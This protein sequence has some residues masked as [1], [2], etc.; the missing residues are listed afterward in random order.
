MHSTAVRTEMA[1]VLGHASPEAID[2]ELAFKDFGFDSLGAIE[3]RN[4]LNAASGLRLPATLI[5]DYPTPILV[6]EHLLAELFPDARP[7]APEEPAEE[8]VR[9]AAAEEAIDAMDVE[10][11]IRMSLEGSGEDVGDAVEDGGGSAAESPEDPGN[12][13]E[14][15]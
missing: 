3:L 12:P 1:A 10:G 8:A 14:E 6:A 7:Q 5:F 2:P 11:L 9:E 15:Q 4:R 13:G